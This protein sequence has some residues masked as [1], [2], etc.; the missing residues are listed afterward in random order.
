M[1][2][3]ELLTNTRV[4][5]LD[6]K[7]VPVLQG[8]Q[9]IA[10]AVR[11]MRAHSH[12]SAMVC[13]DGKLIGIFTERDL[14]KLLAVGKSLDQPLSTVMTSRP[15]T[16]TVDDKMMTVIQLMDEG[17]YRRLPVVDASGSPVG[18]VDVKSV[19]HFLVEHFPKAVYNSAPRALLRARD[20]EGA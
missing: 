5:R 14:L 3:R 11:Q 8:E 13:R 19:V 12:G 17:G 7:E 1:F 6:P 18:I 4:G 2:L 16:V 15:R 10:E 9:P 20:R